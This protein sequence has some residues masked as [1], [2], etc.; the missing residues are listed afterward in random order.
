M[1]KMTPSKLQ[2]LCEN[3]KKAYIPKKGEILFFD[4][5]TGDDPQVLETEAELSHMVESMVATNKPYAIM[6]YTGPAPLMTLHAVNFIKQE[7]IESGKTLDVVNDGM[8]TEDM[9]LLRRELK[10]IKNFLPYK[11]A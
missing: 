5:T 6:N 7:N 8:S 9:L 11:A 10:R 2:S 3:I 4:L 1:D